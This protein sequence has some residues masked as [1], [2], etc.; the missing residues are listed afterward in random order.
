MRFSLSA[1][2]VLCVFCS[3]R[4]HHGGP[5]CRIVP[6]AHPLEAVPIAPHQPR[7]TPSPDFSPLGWRSVVRALR[8]PQ[9]GTCSLKANNFLMTQERS[10]TFM[11]LWKYDPAAEAWSRVA[12]SLSCTSTI[13]PQAKTGAMGPARYQHLLDLTSELGLFWARFREGDHVVGALV[14]SGPVTP[15]DSWIGPPKDGFIISGIPGPDH[16]RAAYVPD[17]EIHCR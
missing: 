12:N 16:A 13:H 1:S 14:Y 10:F 17:P 8:D 3:C 5:P 2:V 6:G 4:T 7:A 9:S 15:N 11:S